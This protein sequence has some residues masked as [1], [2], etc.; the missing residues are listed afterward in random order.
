MCDRFDE[1]VQED[2][3]AIGM[4]DE[5]RAALKQLSSQLPLYINTATP[6]NNI[7]RSLESL[8]VESL[9]AGVFGRPGTKL[10]NLK[11]ITEE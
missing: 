9:F 6:T 10:S 5:T 3:I 7:F 1:V 8:Q 11:R 2:V 4:S